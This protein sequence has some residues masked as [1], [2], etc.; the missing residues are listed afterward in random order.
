MPWKIMS[1]WDNKNIVIIG[2]GAVAHYFTNL[3]IENG[4]SITGIHSR[5]ETTG[6]D[7]AQLYN[8]PFYKVLSATSGDVYFVAV[9][10]DAVI[11]IIN[12]LPKTASV[13]YTSGII[14]LSLIDHPN[15][16]VFYPLQSFDG[17][18]SVK[19]EDI[20]ILIESKSTESNLDLQQL[21]KLLGLPCFLVNSEKRKQ[22]HLCAVFINNFINHMGNIAFDEMKSRNIEI[23]I[24]K[25]L[26]EKTMHQLLKGN[27]I[28]KQTGP[29]KR[30]DKNTIMEH[31][32]M[33]KGDTLD[34]YKVMTNSIL[35]KFEHEL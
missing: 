28:E 27:S 10:D 22:I 32:K 4:I 29:A 19:A 24:L 30:N 33:L 5:N 26:L 17:D 2:S 25:P 16:S 20:P 6:I 12:E 8:I 23:E 31:E 34:V 13:I 1:N 9:K 3:F 18:L 35:K 11:A 14:D 7:I 15:C 21:C